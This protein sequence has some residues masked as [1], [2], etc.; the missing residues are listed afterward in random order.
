MNIGIDQRWV[1]SKK[2]PRRRELLNSILS[3][4]QLKFDLIGDSDSGLGKIMW[5]KRGSLMGK[6][7]EDYVGKKGV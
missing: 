5:A 4:I 6:D 1:G 2:T 3:P 7:G